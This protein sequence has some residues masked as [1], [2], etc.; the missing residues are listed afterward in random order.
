VEEARAAIEVA[1]RTGITW[2]IDLPEITEDA[3][4]VKEA[5]LEPEYALLVGG[6]FQGRAID[7]HLFSFA[8]TAHRIVIEP[9]VYNQ[10]FAYAR[11]GTDPTRYVRDL[12]HYFPDMPDPLRAEIVVPLRRFDGQQHL[13]IVPAQIRVAPAGSR[14]E[15]DSVSPDLPESDEVRNRRLYELSFDL[16]GLD[17]ALLDQ[18]GIAVYWPYTGTSRYWIFGRGTVGGRAPSTREALRWHV[19]RKLRLW[20]DANDGVFPTDVVKGARFGDE[21]FFITGHLNGPACSY[22]LWDFSEPSRNAFAARLPGTEPPRTWGFPEIYGADAYAVWLHALHEG[23]AELCGLIRDEIRSEAPGLA[24]F[25]NTTRMGIFDLCNEH[26]GS[27]QELLAQNLD[28]I[29]L[30]PYPVG[31]WGYGPQIVRDVSY[32]AGLARR[33]RKP[34]IPWMQA[35]TYGGPEG[36]QHVTADQVRRMCDEQWAQGVSG[37]MWLGYGNRYTFPLTQPASWEEAGAFHHKLTRRRPPRPKPELAVLRGYRARAAVSLWEGSV[38]NPADWILQQLLEIW[39]VEM[40][41]PYDVFE[42]P[43]R[44]TASATRRLADRLRNYRWVTGTEPWPGALVFGDGTP[45]IR[46][47]RT[48]EIRAGLRLELR[49]R[50]WA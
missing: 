30:D 14:P 11:P 35:H 27:G 45:P 13:R 41:R 38:R 46:L 43:P 2:H 42:I 19:R 37:V 25:R 47:D 26:D 3:P 48:E 10:S 20:R 21:C 12:G 40:R 4:L 49:A 17:G 33:F 15:K 5:G 16:T 32:C 29:H 7:R 1:R 39:A 36:L 24:L 18:V 9:P 23:C 31:G 8:P 28:I 6:V 34:L 22:P 44:Q 50:G